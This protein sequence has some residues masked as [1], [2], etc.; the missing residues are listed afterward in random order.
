MWLNRAREA[1]RNLTDGMNK[2][3]APLADQGYKHLEGLL[4]VQPSRINELLA[5]VLEGL[6][7][8]QLRDS[9]VQLQE[10]LLGDDWEQTIAAI[11]GAL[12]NLIPR[13]LVALGD[14]KDWQLIDNAQRQIEVEIKLDYPAEGLLFQWQE[15]EKALHPLLEREREAPWTKELRQLGAEF[16]GVLQHPHPDQLKTIFSRLRQKTMWYFYQQ[17]RQLKEL[18][19]ELTRVGTQLEIILK[20]IGNGDD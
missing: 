6:P 10:E 14:H 5:K 15:A 2:R 18:S 13:V 4:R 9:F 19:A 11:L 12:G 3:D 17:D 8:E 7:F 1:H 20:G 16:A